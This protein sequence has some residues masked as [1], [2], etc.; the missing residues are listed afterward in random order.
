MI[1][2]LPTPKLVRCV[3]LCQEDQPKEKRI[4]SDSSGINDHQADATSTLKAPCKQKHAESLRNVS[5]THF[6]PCTGQE[7]PPSS[8]SSAATRVVLV[9]QERRGAGAEGDGDDVS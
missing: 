1:V 7:S 3:S 5:R 8:T 2:V 4:S 9:D 6:S